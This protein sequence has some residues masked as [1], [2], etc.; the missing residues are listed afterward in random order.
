MLKYYILSLLAGVSNKI[1][2]D[3]K[4]N[5]LIENKKTKKNIEVILK[6]LFFICFVLVSLKYPLYYLCF[7]IINLQYLYYDNSAYDS[8]EKNGLL[9]ILLLIPFINWKNTTDIKKSGIIILLIYLCS[10]IFEIKSDFIKV[11]YSLV[12]FI[13][14]SL[15][16]IGNLI[17]FFVNRKYKLYNDNFVLFNISCIGYFTTSAIF[18]YI[19]ISKNKG[20]IY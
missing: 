11:E 15:L 13:Q 2:D 8:Y 9:L 1:Y 19:L 18:Q 4:D 3:I 16:A 7:I 6:I 20:V 5:N 10:Y 14:R 17:L 12:K